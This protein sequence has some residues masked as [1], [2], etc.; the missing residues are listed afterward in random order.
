MDVAHISTIH[1]LVKHTH[2]LVT[3][4]IVQGW[5]L[6]TYHVSVRRG[7]IRGINVHSIHKEEVLFLS[8]MYM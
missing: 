2:V 6:H 1:V 3:E 7:I 5:P 8:G 4:D